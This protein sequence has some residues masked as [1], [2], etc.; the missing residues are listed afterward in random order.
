MALELK[1]HLSPDGCCAKLYSLFVCFLRYCLVG[2]GT[3][4]PL[5]SPHSVDGSK[6]D[7]CKRDRRHL[8]L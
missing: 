1:K 2:R 8:L 3:N 4:L 5:A 6:L 7:S